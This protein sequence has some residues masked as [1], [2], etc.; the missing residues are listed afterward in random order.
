M[1]NTGRRAHG[2]PLTLSL[3]DL[4][5]FPR[6]KQIFKHH[7]I[8]IWLAVGPWEDIRMNTILNKCRPLPQTRYIVFNAFPQAEYAP[9]PYNE[10]LT[11][12][13]IIA[14]PT[15]PGYETNRNSL[16]LPHVAPLPLH[17]EIKAGYQMVRYDCL[18]EIVDSFDKI[19]IGL[20]GYPDFGIMTRSLPYEKTYGQGNNEEFHGQ[21]V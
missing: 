10:D 16:P 17:M 20:G 11:P 4:K 8:Q 3:S 12:E 14:S 9:D 18:I 6:P 15:M 7:R 2:A 13:E 19:G 5:A 1:K 21:K